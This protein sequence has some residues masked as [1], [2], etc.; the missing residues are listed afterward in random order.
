MGC[1]CIGCITCI[2]GV[3]IKNKS[4]SWHKLCCQ[5]LNYIACDKVLKNKKALTEIR[6]FTNRPLFSKHVTRLVPGNK[7]LG[8]AECL[9]FAFAAVLDGLQLGIV[10]IILYYNNDLNV[11]SPYLWF[12]CFSE[13]RVTRPPGDTM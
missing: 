8:G 11:F 12:Q 4:L 2:S 10:I 1:A 9:S 13:V 6:I 3:I 5:V 7:F